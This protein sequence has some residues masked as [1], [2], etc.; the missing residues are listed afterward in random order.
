MS[1][2]VLDSLLQLRALTE[3]MGCL[4]ELQVVQLKNWPW[5]LF[6]HLS[7]CEIVPDVETKIV[8]FNLVLNKKKK[9][10][11]GVKKRYEVLDEWVKTLLGDDWLIKVMSK[12]TPLYVG[13]R[14]PNVKIGKN[15]NGA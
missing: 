13:L 1:A 5:V 10:P 14:K 7:K 8:T 11:K 15:K 2:K 12:E 4:H 3:R 6:T 9:A